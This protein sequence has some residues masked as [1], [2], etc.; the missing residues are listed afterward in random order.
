MLAATAGIAVMVTRISM[1]L[2]GN[3]AALARRLICHVH[4]G[5]CAGA[6]LKRPCLSVPGWD[7]PWVQQLWSYSPQA[8]GSS[9]P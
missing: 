4:R 1:P 7:L 9:C 8:L 2:A 6:R 3:A 5:F